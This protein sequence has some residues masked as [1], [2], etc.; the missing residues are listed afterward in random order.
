M[1]SLA[2]AVHAL[3]TA[4]NPVVHIKR[5]KLSYWLETAP[6]PVV[7]IKRNIYVYYIYVYTLRIDNH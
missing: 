5:H 1:I 7:H 2:L 3:E 4:P 6:N